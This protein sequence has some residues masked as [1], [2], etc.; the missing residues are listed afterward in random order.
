M[1]VLSPKLNIQLQKTREKLDTFSALNEKIQ[2][3]CSSYDKIVQSRIDSRNFQQPQPQPQNYGYYQ[4][5]QQPQQPLYTYDQPQIP[6]P[7][8]MQ[9][10]QMPPQQVSAPY[11]PQTEYMPVQ[12]NEYS[13]VKQGEYIYGQQQQQPQYFHQGVSSSNPFYQQA[14]G[15]VYAVQNNQQG[16]YQ[17]QG[18]GYVP[19]PVVEEKPLIEF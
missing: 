2:N 6:Q 3:G 11:A 8:Q 9:Y 17:N 18:I 14:P 10:Q 1:G 19:Q 13:N 16:N 5:T 12:Q 7:A 4:Q 15:D